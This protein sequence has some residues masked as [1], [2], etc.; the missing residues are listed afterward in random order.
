MIQEWSLSGSLYNWSKLHCAPA[1]QYTTR[2]L[3][4]ITSIIYIWYFSFASAFHLHD[5]QQP[6]RSIALFF[7]YTSREQGAPFQVSLGGQ[8]RQF[9]G[10]RG[11]EISIKIQR[12]V[13]GIYSWSNCKQQFILGRFGIVTFCANDHLYQC[14]THIYFHLSRTHLFSKEPNR[15]EATLKSK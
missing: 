8:R 2:T 11:G 7:P 15:K 9:S 6:M 14:K 4:L 13:C 5:V 12:P 10:V 1:L 3:Q